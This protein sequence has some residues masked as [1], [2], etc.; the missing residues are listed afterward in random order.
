ML[1][2]REPP[3]GRE[4]LSKR[5]AVIVKTSLIGI[6]VNVLL[7]AMKATVGLLTHSIAVVLD[8]VNNLSDALSSVVTIVGAKL[9]SRSADKEHPLGHGRIEYLSAMLVAALVLYA[10]LTSLTESIRKILHPEKAEYTALS[11][12]LIAAAVVVKLLLGRYVKAKGSEVDSD[13]LIA[14]GA[15]ARFDAILSA[16]VL[17]CALIC[18]KTGVSLEAWLGVVIAGFIIKAGIGMMLDT[19][20]D[21]LGQRADP[22]I[23]RKVKE[24]ACME[25]G[26]RGACD[27]TLNNYGPGKNYGSL[28][29]EVPDSFTA[30]QI[31]MISR[32]IVGRVYRETGIALTGIG[33]YSVN[34]RDPEAVKMRET[35]TEALLKRENVLEI[36]GFLV[37][38]SRRDIHF[39]VVLDFRAD[40]KKELSAMTEEVRALYPDYKVSIAPHLDISD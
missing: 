40:L 8:A 32:R 2:I 35:I 19:V 22:E 4:D 29:I 3:E 1:E 24:L 21:I 30:E 9:S 20:N 13:S 27:L 25:P 14:S 26:V 7:S 10:G 15:D 28:Y 38:K 18:L 36:H 12:A 39:F 34:T 17:V 16:S 23:S 33:I 5:S 11:L 6:V 37:D 31:D